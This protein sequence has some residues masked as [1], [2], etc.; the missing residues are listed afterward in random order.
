M[1][2]HRLELTAFGPFAATQSV[3]FD[4]LSAA[5]LFLLHGPTGAGKTSVLDGVCYALYGQVPGARP[6]TRLRSDH[7]A[8]AT[9]TEVVLELTVGAR[10]LEI[11]R[12]PEQPRAKKRGTGTTMDKAVTLLREHKDGQWQALSKS[13][14]EIG[15]EIKQLV[16]MS[17]EQFCQ[18]V[19]LPQGEFATF[20]RASAMERA[21]LL[22]R[23]FDTRRFKAVENWLRERKQAAAERLA[24]GDQGLLQL[25]ERMRQ[26]AGGSAQAAEDAASAD[27]D[28]ASESRSPGELLEWAAVLRCDAREA[29]DIAGQALAHAETEHRAAAADFDAARDLHTL[30]ARHADARRRAAALDRERDMRAAARDRLA[31]AHRAGT[32]EPALDLREKAALQHRDALAAESEALAD[33]AATGELPPPTVPHDRSS[34]ET[35]VGRASPDAA[36]AGPSDPQAVALRRERDVG[37]DGSAASWAEAGGGTPGPDDAASGVGAERGGEVDGSRS[38]TAPIGR[39]VRP[40]GLCGG[41]PGVQR[42]GG[43]GAAGGD[44]SAVAVASAGQHARR[45]EALVRR[46]GELR[47]EMGGLARAGEAEARVREITERRVRLE[48]E[49]RA[50]EGAVRDADSWLEEWPAVRAALQ[51]RADGAA[52]AAAKAAELA[53]ELETARR[54]SDAAAQ[55]DRLAAELTHAQDR[56]RN[57]RDRAAQAREAWQDL[58]QA[59]I[60][61]I[62]AELAEQLADGEPCRVCGSAEHPAPARPVGRQITRADEDAAGAAYERAA[63]A[64]ESARGEADRLAAALEAAT[65]T[66]GDEPRARLAAACAVLEDEYAGAAREAA[67]LSEARRAVGAAE[68][69]RD[70]RTAQRHAAQS[71]AAARTS[72]REELDEQHRRLSAELD[73]ARAGHASVAE[74]R[75][76]L[77]ARIALLDRAAGAVR[78]RA[79]SAQRLAEADAALAAAAARAGFATPADAE[80]ALLD[81]ERLWRAE[82][83]ADAWAKEEAALEADLAAP[84]PAAAAQLPPAE[85]ALAQAA[86]SA[87]TDRLRAASAAEAAAVTRRTELDRLS[88]RA[89]ALTRQLAPARAD[90]DAIARLSDLAS[91]TTAQNRYRMELETYV[92]AARLEQVAAAAAV[93]LQRMSA[94]RYTLVHTDARGGGRSKSGLGLMVVD[95]WTGTE[96]D[97]ATLSG[98][99]TFFASLALALGLADVVTDE[100]GGARLDTL[101]IDEGFGSLDD[102]TLD[103]VLDV[104][105][106]LRERDRAVGIVSH[107]AD[108]R[109]R[110]P[111]QL[112]VVKGRDG[113]TVRMRTGGTQV[114]APA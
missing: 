66:A 107:V 33:L 13:H 81:L 113:S 67:E 80:A 112:R 87:A 47:E 54:R 6:A 21:A 14:Q 71:R 8:A 94:G 60:D 62:A 56:A 101:F 20:L 32:V 92:L 5:G 42:P 96:R 28:G 2:L 98:G 16:G 103:E 37:V 3:D 53:A 104:L 48:R 34:T 46:V 59:R 50:D 90:F 105:D 114:P 63:Q 83:Q 86:L 64:H 73:R 36:G 11:T 111:T 106:G 97:T 12:R 40:D 51:A 4:E 69:E 31:R 109:H 75:S 95:A 26:A 27:A 29:A 100:A 55:R 79:E 78:D 89:A 58:R 84:E 17:C 38:A 68:Q 49:E 72:R 74:R 10:R 45:A 70:R 52:E 41:G 23:L 44:G 9:P 88:D 91:A 110:I 61:G 35:R 19:L 43:A 39:Q 22:G 30:Q 82:R 7:A 15:E 102:Q 99:E 65:A 93:R 1:R 25:A 76:R 24:A 57:V 18:V 85:P 77:A 108:L